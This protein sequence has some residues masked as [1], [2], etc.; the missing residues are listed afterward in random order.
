MVFPDKS[1]RRLAQNKRRSPITVISP[2]VLDELGSFVDAYPQA[3][4][5]FLKV[6]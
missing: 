4:V 2:M 6:L 3:T 1:A 5:V